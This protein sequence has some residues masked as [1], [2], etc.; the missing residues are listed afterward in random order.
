MGQNH[1]INQFDYSGRV[2]HVG[3]PETFVTK[4]GQTKAFR[5][6]VMETFIGQYPREVMFEFNESNMTQLNQITDGCW[7]TITFCLS[8]NK[9]IKDGRAKWFNK[10]EGLTCIKG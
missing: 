2:I 4:S 5:I 9:T 10:L 6:L 1:S 7:A 3:P 8:G